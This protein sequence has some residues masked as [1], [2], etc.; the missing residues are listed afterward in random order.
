MS[1]GGVSR[2]RFKKIFSILDQKEVNYNYEMTSSL[3]DAKHLSGKANTSEY[4]VIVAVGGDGTINSVLNGFYDDQGCRLSRAKMGVIYTG[5]SPDFCKSYRIPLKLEKAI[6]VIMDSH[7]RKIK[8]GM[9]RCC[10]Q[11]NIALNN[12]ALSDNTPAHIEFFGCCANIGLGASLAR[13]ANSGIRK[14]LGDTLGTF[15]AL[16]RV[17]SLYKANTFLMLING[18]ETAVDKLYNISIGRTSYIA[19]GIKVRHNLSDEDEGFYC[20]TARNLNPGNILSVLY[21]AYSGKKIKNS[22]YLYLDYCNSIE[23]YGNYL[24]PELEFDGDPGG[25]LPCKIEIAKDSL[26]LITAPASTK[27]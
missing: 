9:I 6:G 25:Y 20:M 27:V 21:K 17:L 26:D 18:K 13:M 8:V 24:N 11:N 2:K 16:L 4:D 22:D 3:E 1:G 12:N 15:M 19:S 14:Y 7:V 10:N 5:T 23:I